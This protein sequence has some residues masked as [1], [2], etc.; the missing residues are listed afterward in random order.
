MNLPTNGAPNWRGH[1]TS[2]WTSNSRVVIA[3]NGPSLEPQ[4]ISFCKQR[5]ATMLAVSDSYRLIPAPEMVYAADARWWD[6]HYETAA[7]VAG[8]AVFVCRQRTRYP[9]VNFLDC[10][11]WTWRNA[12]FAL[13]GGNSGYQALMLA[14]MLGAR[15]I[16]LLGFDCKNNRDGRR[17]W[18][19]DH[20]KPLYNPGP[21]EYGRWVKAFAEA[22]AAISEIGAEVV[23]CSPDSALTMF[24]RQRLES[25][26]WD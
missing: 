12:A 24:P 16:V 6:I 1:K 21:V 20:P 5:G 2:R 7:R 15:R 9:D 14:V 23:N 22:A 13:T 8:G 18:F 11:G 4:Q 25:L 10:S 19:G 17:H 26:A 3:A